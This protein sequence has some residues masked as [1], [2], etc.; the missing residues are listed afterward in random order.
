MRALKVVAQILV[1]ACPRKGRDGRSSAQGDREHIL[2]DL[3]QQMIDAERFFGSLADRGNLGIKGRGIECG[4]AECAETAG[5]RYGG[6]Q[7]RGGRG[8]H[9][10]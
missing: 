5:V 10:P 2:L 8:T 6:Y 9:P 7:R 4:C 3:K 1:S